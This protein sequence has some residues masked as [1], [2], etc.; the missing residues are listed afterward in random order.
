MML[1]YKHSWNT[2]RS[3]PC[4]QR[5]KKRKNSSSILVPFSSVILFNKSIPICVLLF[6]CCCFKVNG[7]NWL[8]VSES[9]N[10]QRTVQTDM[11]MFFYAS[12]LSIDDELIVEMRFR[13]DNS[14]RLTTI[15]STD[16]ETISAILHHIHEWFIKVVSNIYSR[17]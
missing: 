6:F 10:V 17:E 16:V 4:L 2:W 12:F 15:I 7:Q 3:L 14:S 11:Q 9:F 13:K 8:S 1:I 5:H